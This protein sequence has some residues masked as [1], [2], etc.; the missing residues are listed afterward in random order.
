M[1]SIL[2]M[3]QFGMGCHGKTDVKFHQGMEK[4]KIIRLFV[5][6]LYRLGKI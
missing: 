1:K 4:W 5:T 3:G 2:N 6:L